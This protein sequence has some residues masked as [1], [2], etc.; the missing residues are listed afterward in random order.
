MTFRPQRYLPTPEHPYTAMELDDWKTELA[1]AVQP[2]HRYRALMAVAYLAAPQDA[3]PLQCRALGDADG[4]VR[5]LAAKQIGQLRRAEAGA[6]ISDEDWRSVVPQLESRLADN[7]PDVR[8]ESARALLRIANDHAGAAAIIF[9]ALA[10]EGTTPLMLA[11]L[12]D[13]LG[14]VA[15]DTGRVVDR[16]TAL[17]SHSQ[18]EVRENATSSLLKLGSV[19]QPALPAILRLVD[20]EEPWVRENAVKFLAQHGKAT[21]EVLA[22]LDIA[23]SDE[24]TQIAEL[25]KSARAEVSARGAE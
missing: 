1:G 14:D 3:W 8:F 17:L 19:A 9:E 16:L 7:D 10:E 4:M 18:A 13:V 22:A 11:A 21:P 6:Q 24:D 20:D 15:V 23:A 5:S 2:E 25:A 12:A